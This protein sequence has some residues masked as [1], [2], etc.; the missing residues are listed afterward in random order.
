[1]SDHAVLEVERLSVSIAG[2]NVLDD[3]SFEIRQGEFTGLIGS[4]GVGRPR[5]CGPF[6]DFNA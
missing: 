5:C 6:W 1:M 2:R 3:V 4:N